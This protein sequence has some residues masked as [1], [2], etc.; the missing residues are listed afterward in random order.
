MIQAHS[1]QRLAVGRAL[2]HERVCTN[3]G[4]EIQKQILKWL[5]GGHLFK[6][7]GQPSRQIVLSFAARVSGGFAYVEGTGDESGNSYRTCPG[8]SE[9]YPYPFLT[10][11]FFMSN[12]PNECIQ[13]SKR[14]ARISSFSEIHVLS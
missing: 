3:T 7:T 6:I 1:W 8:C 9:S 12:S 14:Y 2:R 13:M 5:E 4:S 10:G 11:L